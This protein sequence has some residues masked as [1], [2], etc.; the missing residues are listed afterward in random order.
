VLLDFYGLNEQPFGVTPDPRFIYFGPKHREALASLVY[1]T[2]SDRGFIALIAKPGMG[3]TSLLYHYLEGLRNKALTAFVFQTDCHRRELL[4]HILADLGRDAT[5]KDL[6]AMHEMFNKLLMKEMHA[7][8]RV[9]LVID[10]A[11]NLEEK[12]LESIRLLSNFET[13][14]MKLVQIILAGQPQLAGRLSQPSLAQLRQRISMFVRIEPFNLGEIG[15]Y[16]HHRLHIAG[17]KGSS[18]FTAGAQAMIAAGSEGIPRNINNICFN[19]MSLACALKQKTVNRE[20]VTEVLADLDPGSVNV[21]APVIAR[22]EQPLERPVLTMYSEARK[23][24]PLHG[25]LPKLTAACILL[26]ALSWPLN[27]ASSTVH[28]APASSV[29]FGAETLVIASSAVQLDDESKSGAVQVLSQTEPKVAALEH[30]AEVPARK[31]GFGSADAGSN[32]SE[33]FR[34]ITVTPGQT[35]YRIVVA[36]FG[37]YNDV[38]LREVRALNPRLVDLGHVRP[39]QV[40]VLPAVRNPSASKLS[41]LDRNHNA[42]AAAA[43]KQ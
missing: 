31:L 32:T 21:E 13:P 35:F 34:S 40:I 20:I 33:G 5:G 41:V 24:L 25:W 6:P 1:G 14:W 17:Y 26:F 27:S 39:G 38:I 16:I 15:E 43:E 19:A 29:P 28:S 12:A 7:G 2:Q 9:V 11:Q 18:P 42:T 36:N 23:R 8:R 3:K 37:T 4:R 22:P 10:E 30:N